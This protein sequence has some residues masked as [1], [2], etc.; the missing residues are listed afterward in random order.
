MPC[1]WQC[2]P[3]LRLLE[4]SNSSL[5]LALSFLTTVSPSC[6]REKTNFEANMS[7]G[8]SA[9]DFIAAGKLIKDIVS[10]LNHDAAS[11]Y[12][13]LILELHG[14]KRALGEI[15]HLKCPPCQ[16]AALNSVKVAALMCQYPLD[17]FAN[18]LGKYERLGVLPTNSERGRLKR[19]GSKLRWVAGMDDDVAKLRAYITAHVGS[20]NMRLITLG[21]SAYNLSQYPM[22]EL[23]LL[24]KDNFHR[25]GTTQRRTL[26]FTE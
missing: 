12:L 7:F 1:L 10:A 4:L 5:R 24:Q 9:G 19:L 16:E 8:F 18:K 22:L 2:P 20:L 6:F 11:S 21:L 14:L 17:E 13:E 26:S 15:E 3:S 25:R 23:T